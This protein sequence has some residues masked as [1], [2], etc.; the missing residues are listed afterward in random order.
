[1]SDSHQ[2]LILVIEDDP[3]IRLGLRKSLGYEGYRVVDAADGE[4][5]LELV[6]EKKPDLVV[7]DLMLP[8]VNGFEICRTIRRHAP[9]LPV[10]ILSAKDQEVDKLVGFDLGADDY[11]TKP[12]STRE[13][14]ARIKAAL[15]R[16][17]VH[18]GLEEPFQHEHLRLD[19]AG[20]TL[21]VDGE[22]VEV[23]NREFR[24]LCYLV[25]NR[26]RVL[27]RDK[28]L[29]KV[30]GYDYEG[31]A[32][33]IDNFINKL[34]SKIERDPARPRFIRTVRGVGYKFGD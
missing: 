25:E 1:M 11:V 8:K 16:T 12:F 18:E 20:Q 32:R 27:S 28:I 22:P 26:G 23:S 7:L 4:R 31:T 5:G 10:L 24:L 19:P 34:R 14:T 6:F 29:N 30:W 13:L 9:S 21:E 33:T 17:Q 3:A 15:R 2:P